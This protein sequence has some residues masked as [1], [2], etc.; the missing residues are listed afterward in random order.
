MRCRRRCSSRR[1]RRA[2]IVISSVA[3]GDGV[4]TL[5]CSAATEVKALRGEVPVELVE[6]RQRG[7]RHLWQLSG[8][9][10][11]SRVVLRCLG[12]AREELTEGGERVERAREAPD[13]DT[14]S[15]G[16]VAPRVA[17][18][19]VT[20]HRGELSV[21]RGVLLECR[22]LEQRQLLVRG[23]EARERAGGRPDG[24]RDG[25]RASGDPLGPC[26]RPRAASARGGERC[27]RTVRACDPTSAMKP[28]YATATSRTSPGRPQSRRDLRTAR[29]SL[30]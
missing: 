8:E 24:E 29:T 11:A 17:S 2:Q 6:G 15:L 10:N 5:G 16:R 30:R 28:S 7:S 4:H 3:R 20:Q 22:R 26:A 13:E 14:R 21:G 9:H 23:R 19:E 27:Q 1:R 18:V 12:L 25:R